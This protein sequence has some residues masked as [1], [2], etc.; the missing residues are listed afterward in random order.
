[1]DFADSNLH[2]LS[3]STPID[4]WLS[5]ESLQ[6][7]LYSLPE[8]PTAIPYITSYYAP[9]W[10][11]CLSHQLRESLQPGSY[12][13]VIRSTLQPGALTYGELLLPGKTEEEVFLS[14]Y[15]CHPS[16]ANNELSGPVVCT[17]LALWLKSLP[18]RRYTYRLIF[19]PETI[20]SIVYLSRNIEHLKRH[21]VA[22]FNVTC[23]GDE[24]AF[25]FLPSRAGNT[26]ADQAAIHSLKHVAGEFKRYTWRDRGSDERQYCA[27]GVDLALCSIMRTKYGEYPEYHT[28]LDDLALVT[29][30]GLAGG[31]AALRTAIE[32]IEANT[33]PRVTVLCEPQLGKRG[34]YPTLSTRDTQA[35]VAAMMDLISYSDGKRTLLEI[36][37]LIDVPIST[38]RQL[39]EPLVANGLIELLP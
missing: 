3:Y 30:S 19:V 16:M 22:G 15:V 32:A 36:A 39:I 21:V 26:L 13:A 1:V 33:R 6:E 2:V 8:Q 37:E 7:H 24:R 17:A 28:S 31:F 25:S 14:T 12:H 20:G 29:P 38:L 35:Q 9:R 18:T 23:V 34:L 10:G 5:L 4:E 11:F 27:P